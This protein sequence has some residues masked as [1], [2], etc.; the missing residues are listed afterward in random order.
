MKVKIF[1]CVELA[2][3]FFSAS[4]EMS[5]NYFNDKILINKTFLTNCPTFFRVDTKNAGQ[6]FLRQFIKFAAQHFA[7]EIKKMLGRWLILI[8]IR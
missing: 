1:M 5:G 4:K 8:F 7:I 2:Q 6:L 3:H